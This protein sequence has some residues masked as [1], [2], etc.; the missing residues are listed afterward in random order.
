MGIVTMILRLSALEHAVLD[1]ISLQVPKLADELAQLLLRVHV[2]SC[3]NTGAGLYTALE[4]PSDAILEGI[5]SPVGDVGAA[6]AGLEHGMGFLLWLEDGRM[7]QLEGYSY[8][9]STSD[10]DFERVD[11]GTVGPR[12]RSGHKFQA[13]CAET[14][15]QRIPA[16]RKIW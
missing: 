2:T 11:F 12:T 3:L 6:V 15:P 13:D 5:K 8:E 16:R 1:A 7:H 14:P 4:V 9:E 10:L